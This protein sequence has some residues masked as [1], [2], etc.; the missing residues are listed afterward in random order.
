[1]GS[2]WFRGT[3]SNPL[4]E[5]NVSGLRTILIGFGLPLGCALVGFFAGV[6]VG[7]EVASAHVESAPKGVGHG[8]AYV[9]GGLCILVSLAG[10]LVGAVSGGVLAV[11]C[12]WD[13]STSDSETG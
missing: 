13:R 5:G 1:M 11:L 12:L 2:W 4:G 8:P 3:E 7:L 6:A 9:A 10:L